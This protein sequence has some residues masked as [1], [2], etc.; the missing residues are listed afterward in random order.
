MASV[1]EPAGPDSRKN[2]TL[3]TCRSDSDK[4]DAFARHAQGAHHEA[5]EP[6]SPAAGSGITPATTMAVLPA[7]TSSFGR[8]LAVVGKIAAA[9]LATF[10]ARFGCAFRII[11]EVAAAVLAAFA[12]RFGC[13]FRIVLEVP[14]AVLTAFAASLGC[15]FRVVLEVTAVLTALVILCHFNYLTSG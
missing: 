14:A 11:L 8:F 5:G 7:F 15:A 2:S 9:V 4:P 12:A 10:A 13:A 1:G 3:K 6:G